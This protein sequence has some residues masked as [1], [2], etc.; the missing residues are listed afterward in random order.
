M[1]IHQDVSSCTQCCSI[2]C[3]IMH[4]YIVASKLRMTVTLKV[5][6]Y[7]EGGEVGSYTEGWEVGSYTAGGEMGSYTKVGKWGARLR[8][9][10]WEVTPKGGKRVR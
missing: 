8:V 1:I 4:Q 2:K 10:K 3:W 9:G 5:G 6:S 7:T